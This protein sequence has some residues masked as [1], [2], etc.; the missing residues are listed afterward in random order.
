MHDLPDVDSDVLVRL[1]AMVQMFQMDLTSPADYERLKQHLDGTEQVSGQCSH[2]LLYLSMPPQVFAPVIQL[3]GSADL[4]AG[5]PHGQGQSRLLIEKPFG[6]DLASAKELAKTIAAQFNEEHIFR[7]DHYVAKEASQNIS[8]F[9]R[10][11]PLFQ[12]VWNARSIDSIVVTAAETIGVEDRGVFYDQT[13]ALRDVLQNHLMQLLA[14]ITMEL[15]A[16]QTADTLH[17][18]KLKLLE[19]IPAIAPNEVAARTVRGQYRGYRDE[20][21]QPDSATET[22][23]A[24][25]LAIDNDRWRGVPVIL[26]TG[27]ALAAKQTEVAL[28]FGT[29]ELI[30]RIEPGEGICLNLLVKKPGLDHELQPVEM[31][32]RYARSFGQY[33]HPDAYER[34]LADA[35]R[36][37]RTLFTTSAETLECWRIVDA[38]VREWGKSSEGMITYQP[39]TPADALSQ[40]L[41]DSRLK[42]GHY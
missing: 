14:L 1:M 38:V 12:A 27:K 2:R 36:G 40:L 31:D 25:K 18:A 6:Y 24:V 4:T 7:I 32:F 39:S 17:A 3:L 33:R 15:P 30:I 35:L 34:V 37:D 10:H 5:C 42:Q 22:F 8:A 23:A 41:Q 13:G 29:N 21:G 26:Q 28:R 19:A 9:R 20:V 16:N 11:N